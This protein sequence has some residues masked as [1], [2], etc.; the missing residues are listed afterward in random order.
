[1]REKG[2]RDLEVVVDDVGF[3][4]F[5]GRVQDLVWPRDFDAAG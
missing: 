5:A 2:W 1:M 4:E 3:G